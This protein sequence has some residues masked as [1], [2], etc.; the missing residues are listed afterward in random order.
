MKSETEITHGHSPTDAN[1][2]R[3]KWAGFV[4]ETRNTYAAN[5]VL[6]GWIQFIP[7]VVIVPLNKGPFD[8]AT[9][10]MDTWCLLLKN[11][12]DFFLLT[13]TDAYLWY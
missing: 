9:C 12:E 8:I 1:A 7:H 10:N 2:A 3:P 11:C 4:Q 5:V 6:T 13:R